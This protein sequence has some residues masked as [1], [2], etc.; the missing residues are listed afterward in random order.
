MPPVICIPFSIRLLAFGSAYPGGPSPCPGHYSQAFDYYA[1][2]VLPSARWQF[3]APSLGKAVW[4]FP[5]SDS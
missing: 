3:R 2:S 1:A 4:E 5:S